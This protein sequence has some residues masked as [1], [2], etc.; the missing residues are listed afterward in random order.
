M[1]QNAWIKLAL[2]AN[3]ISLTPEFV[4]WF[5]DT[6]GFV[7][8]RDF[9]NSPNWGP[10]AAPAPPQEL[11]LSGESS[12][13]VAVNDYGQTRWRLTWAE[14]TGPV[15]VSEML[16]EG[17]A[18]ELLK[19]PGALNSNPE[20]ARVSNLYGGSALAFFS[21]RACYF[22]AEG[23]GC[24]FCSLEGTARES[25][26][27][28]GR[29]T[30]DEVRNA[31]A[32]VVADDSKAINQVMIVGG[33]ERDLDRG[34]RNQ[35]KLVH[36]ASDALAEAG[37]TDDV[38]VHLVAMP[39]RDLQIIDGLG[40]IPN[41]HAGFDLEAWNPE[42]F[43]AV[44]PGKHAD[45]GQ[46]AILTAL[47]RL[48]DVVG[49]Y[50]A[51]SILIAGLEPAESTLD[52]AGKLAAEGIS[53]II[54]A[55]HSDRHSALGLSIRPTYRHLSEVASGLQE[56]HDTY[57]IQPYWKGCGRNAMDFEASHGMFHGPVPQFG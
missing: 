10:T 12:V 37:L 50:R 56:L 22:F 39:P 34:F 25:N 3:G 17:R 2:L 47:E 9:Y 46:R 14:D 52:G 4:D 7:Q 15:V 11:R 45:Y 29:L 27:Y 40:D 5:R 23:T 30:Y 36:A 54:N 32:S 20:I 44:A 13:I 31:V 33:N 38:S 49:P 1:S 51:H 53:P 18:V 26:E 35:L 21:P 19:N 24:R 42:R 28:A 43:A 16:P 6:D 55:Y 8:R 41:V 48:R 57:P